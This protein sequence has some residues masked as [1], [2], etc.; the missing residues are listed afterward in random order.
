[1]S[2]SLGVRASSGEG[3]EPGPPLPYPHVA[4][5][6][7]PEPAAEIIPPLKPAG[8]PRSP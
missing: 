8:S 5:E 6:P 7:E 2:R 3:F 4:A 1:M